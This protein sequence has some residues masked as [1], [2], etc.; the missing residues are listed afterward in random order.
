MINDVVNIRRPYTQAELSTL[1]APRMVQQLLWPKITAPER[2]IV[3]PM[4]LCRLNAAILLGVELFVLITVH[5]SREYIASR[6][7]ARPQRSNWHDRPPFRE[8]KQKAGANNHAS[9]RQSLAPAFVALAFLD[10][11]DDLVFATP[12]IYRDSM[13]FGIRRDAQ[14]PLVPSAYRAAAPSIFHC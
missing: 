7:T 8:R 9:L 1:L 12:A 5:F 2:E 4:P 13:R 10:I 11:H 3:Q 14:Q 6:V